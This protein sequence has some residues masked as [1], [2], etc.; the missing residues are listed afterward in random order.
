MSKIYSSIRTLLFLLAFWVPI[1]LSAQLCGVYTI[2]GAS[3]TS[4]TNFQTFS[5]AASSLNT[6]GV[7]CAVTF[8][9]ATGTYNENVSLGAIT[10]VS[11]TNTISFVGA[12]A[13][14]TILTHDGSV[15]QATLQLSGT[16]YITFKN[17][18]VENTKTGVDAWGIHLSNAA[19]YVTIDSCNIL[20]PISSTADVG[21]IVA[22]SSL[23]AL[24]GQGNNANHLS[25]TNCYV[26][27]SYQ[28]IRLNGTNSTTGDVEDLYL[29]NNEFKY[30]YIAAIQILDAKEVWIEN[31]D[32][33]SVSTGGTDY[34]INL[35]RVNDYKVHSNFIKKTAGTG[36]RINNGN[37][38][39]TTTQ[40]SEV[41][42]NIIINTG[43]V[44]LNPVAY[45]NTNI[46][47]N[48][49][50]ASGACV[51]SN[52]HTAVDIR[53]NVFSST[54]AY[55][56]RSQ[57]ALT[58]A[59]TIDYNMY[60]SPSGL[61]FRVIADEYADLAAWQAASPTYNSNSI[62]ANPDFVSATDLHLYND[63][64]AYNN[65]V[66][67]GVTFDF[68]GDIRP[69]DGGVD[70]GA[71]EFSLVLSNY[72][73]SVDAIIEPVAAFCAGLQNIKVVVTNSG[74][75]AI[76][77]INL[78]L[79]LTGNLDSTYNLGSL[80]IPSLSSDTIDLGQYLF[81][82]GNYY[83]ITVV[84]FDP[85]GMTDG[86][87]NND[88]LSVTGITP[89]LS[90]TYT[91]DAATATGGSNF[92]SFTDVA[93]ILNT[94]GICGPTVFNVASATYSENV[95]LGD[96]PGSS[97][98]NTITFNGADATTT[99]LTYDGA[100]I[101]A[102]LQM[103]G[104]N[105]IN[106][107]NLTF[108]TTKTT[109]DAWCVHLSGE[110]NKLTMDS[111]RFIMPIATTADVFGLVASA[112]LTA[113]STA[114]ENAD[115][116]TVTNSYFVGGQGGIFIEG[117]T[118][119][120]YGFNFSNNEFNEHEV[121][122]IGTDNV[123]DIVIY[124]N[125]IN[126]TGTT[127]TCDGI[128][129]Y[130]SNNFRVNNN[131]INVPDFGLYIFDGND[132]YT[133]TTN[134]EVIN[135]MIISSADASIRFSDIENTN[136]YHNSLIGSPAF[137]L[138][139][140]TAVDVRNNIFS[141]EGTFAVDIE[142]GL[143][144]ADSFDYNMYY[145]TSGTI[146]EE[147]GAAY[148]DLAAWQTANPTY[149]L[150]S[151]EAA[152]VFVSSTDLHMNLDFNAY[153]NGTDVGVTTDIDGEVRPQN[154]SFDIGADEFSVDLD[155][156]LSVSLLIDPAPSSNACENENSY[157][158]FVVSNYAVQDRDTIPYVIDIVGNSTISIV[159]TSFNNIPASGSDTITVGP[160]NTTGLWASVITIST[161]LDSDEYTLND[162]SVA[163]V[164]YLVNSLSVD[165]GADTSYC[166]GENF[167]LT[168]DA[169]VASIYDWSTTETTQ[170]ID[171]TS[172]G[173][174]SVVV[175]DFTGCTATDTLVVVENGIT[176]IDLG[177]DTTICTNGTF[178]LVLDA[179]MADTYEW[180]TTETTPTI[181]V[182]AVGEY[183]VSAT[184]AA[185]CVATDT[186]DVQVASI[187]EVEAGNDTVWCEGTSF[188]LPANS[189]TGLFY[190]WTDELE[191]IVTAVT[192]VGTYYVTGTANGCYGTDSMVVAA[193]NTTGIIDSKS[194][195]NV[196]VYPN[197][198]TDF[199]KINVN[200]AIEN[201]TIEF[202]SVTGQVVFNDNT[203]VNGEM[204]LDLSSVSKGIY[205]LKLSTESKVYVQQ[206]VVQ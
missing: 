119:F 109:T 118:A 12:D 171:V 43:G 67:L 7:S 5:D 188:S 34:G 142:D 165:F 25:I 17:L 57:V 26:E 153:N 140:Q 22:S 75:L 162:T 107:K 113:E 94:V 84:S 201:I 180:S 46:Y 13:A 195:L 71:D 90:G 55:A 104:T 8:N 103:E 205:F 146:V 168:L 49:F 65:A 27:G 117:A 10:G 131:K 164:L 47:H 2:D 68:D 6:I 72:D 41:Y 89:S 3:P 161:N 134:S 19:D 38:G 60:Y 20:M 132:G 137:E 169:G 133:T 144:A 123:E 189:A 190:V 135:N 102:T 174:Y 11:A 154:G 193:C 155:N 54:G 178:S 79:S 176:P 86:D 198:A 124:N 170:T 143:T 150:N 128:Y 82:S 36:I 73:V 203:S 96:I 87:L 177:N 196:D 92:Q 126:Y 101:E 141:G 197:P 125:S 136:V 39:Y 122:A 66:D 200:E 9:V 24:S 114:G 51:L 105:N 116:V 159:D 148:T 187:P 181:E 81:N 182:S 152:P 56:F 175:E 45:S 108:E 58:T 106:F 30:Q 48:T 63:L 111:C 112:S 97:S 127:T 42:N 76:D 37:S 44:C 184:N 206:V 199:V 1:G 18:T 69:M 28:G 64:N 16:N 167:S 120:S 158:T 129:L 61:P 85:N 23:T 83:D 194:A 163:N 52:S 191:N 183:S 50:V 185:G 149:N 115:S 14:T 98:I 130:D 53:N 59:D 145:T 31:N 95:Y 33:D 29:A 70:I 202:V 121:Q 166:E 204:Y 110:V 21:G 74:S 80:N 138:N 88:T 139:D 179:G 172:A 192:A 93:A 62:E 156:D 15:S 35:N 4:G 91:I 160:I 186:I 147:N 99:I 173:T 157:I 100:A 78:T 40:N 77:S 32:I 151:I